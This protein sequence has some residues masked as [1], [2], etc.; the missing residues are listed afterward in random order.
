MKQLWTPW[1]M[2]YILGMKKNSDLKKQ[3][4]IFCEKLKENKDED[5]FILY[6]GKTAFIILNIFPYNNGH[7]MVAPYKHLGELERLKDEELGELMSLVKKSTGLLKKAL[8]PQGFNIGLNIGRVAGAGI[9]D[10]I[11]I[12]I[13]PRWEGDTNFLPLIGETKVI[14]E[15]LKDTYKKLLGALKNESL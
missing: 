11:H 15:L 12:H 4:C 2:K 14:P 7:L 6:R 3:G 9:E 1:R 8:N 13:V 5:N 10:H